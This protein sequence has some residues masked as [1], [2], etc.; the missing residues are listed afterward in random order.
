MKTKR[1]ATL[2]ASPRPQKMRLPRA[3]DRQVIEVDKPPDAPVHLPEP[4]A[5]ES[6]LSEAQILK[7]FREFMT[8]RASRG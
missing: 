8:W 5:K 2:A 6:V 4:K 1:R 7:L 3:P